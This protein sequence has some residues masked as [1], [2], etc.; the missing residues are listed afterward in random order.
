MGRTTPSIGA[1]PPSQ[2]K[3]ARAKRAKQTINKDIPTLLQAYPR[4]RKGIEASELI[5][6]PPAVP[7]VDKHKQIN[8]G[9]HTGRDETVPEASATNSRSE[10]SGD[11][12][13]PATKPLTIRLRVADT[14]DAAAELHQD[15]KSRNAKSSRIAI[16]NM[17]SPL[18]PGGGFLNGA[19]S[20][21]ESLCMRTTLHPSLKEEFYRLPEI[22][23]IYTR[24]VLVFRNSDADAADLPKSERF[25][26]DVITAAMHRMPETEEDE[27]G[28]KT[29]ANDK[30]RKTAEQKMRAVMRIAK[31]RGVK[32][33]VLGAWGCGAY[34]NP[35]GEIA[36]AWRRALL[37]RAHD[38]PKGKRKH[39]PSGNESWDGMEVVF[40]VKETRIAE[41]LTSAF[42][43]G[44]TLDV[45]SIETSDEDEEDVEDRAAEGELKDK[46]AELESQIAATRSDVLKDRLQNVLEKLR[47]SG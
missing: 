2:R 9:N 1:P 8:A 11:G 41:I 6:D 37:G 43:G 5:T 22:G 17:A 25:F 13:A 18:R 47:A 16:L 14:L 35:V 31:S 46:I 29:Y 28:A 39:N 44:L 38:S 10:A 33:L 20:Q 42:G 45:A 34:G 4:A 7:T 15:S 32:S 21:E 27:E 24:D 12:P 23:A 19:T 36:A 3:D 30:D 40:A 26:V